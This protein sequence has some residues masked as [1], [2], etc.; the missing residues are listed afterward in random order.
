MC[1]VVDAGRGW[2]LSWNWQPA[3]LHGAAR[4]PACFLAEWGLGSKT[5]Q[6]KREKVKV[7]SFRRPGW[8]QK[9]AHC[10]FPY[11]LLAKESQSLDSMTPATERK[12]GKGYKPS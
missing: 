5:E 12:S 8:A 11:N 10:Y 7:A 1:L 2:G 4:M 9:L 3:H 6:P